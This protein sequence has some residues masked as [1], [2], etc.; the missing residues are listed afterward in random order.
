MAPK[1]RPGKCLI[2]PLPVGASVL[3]R[4]CLSYWAPPTHP[5]TPT[6]KAPPT[7]KNFILCPTVLNRCHVNG[8]DLCISLI[9]PQSVGIYAKVWMYLFINTSQSSVKISTITITV[10]CYTEFNVYIYRP[11]CTT[12]LCSMYVCMYILRPSSVLY[13]LPTCLGG[14][15]QKA[16]SCA[17]GLSFVG[18]WKENPGLS[19]QRSGCTIT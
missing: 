5:A 13:T 2:I 7:F 14:G 9:S 15:R 3:C 11:D 12:P 10:N 4:R 8:Q 18:N 17:S 6:A 19:S 1:G 16:V